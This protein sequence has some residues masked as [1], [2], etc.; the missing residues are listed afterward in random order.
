MGAPEAQDFTAEIKLPS[1]DP[2]IAAADLSLV[3]IAAQRVPMN[4]KDIAGLVD[5]IPA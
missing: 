1:V 5:V 2:V 4:T 3:G